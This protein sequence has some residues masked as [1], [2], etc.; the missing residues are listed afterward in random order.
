[1][2]TKG[3]SALLLVMIAMLIGTALPR[4]AYADNVD[5]L[6]RE[7]DAD[8]ERVRLSAVLNLTK[9]GDAASIRS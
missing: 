9:L 2:R 8:S 7:L 6:I 1:M 3:T 5:S 4:F